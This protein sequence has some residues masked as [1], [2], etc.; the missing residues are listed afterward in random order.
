MKP[1]VSHPQP[2]VPE[3]RS[4]LAAPTGAEVDSAFLARI[5]RILAEQESP[6][7]MKTPPEVQAKVNPE[8]AR[9]AQWMTPE[10]L[11]RMTDD[12]NLQYHYGGNDVLTWQSPQG[13]VVLAVGYDQIGRVLDHLTPEQNLAVCT[14]FAHPW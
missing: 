12:F 14:R 10:A 5:D 2:T 3:P 7:L 9:L 6:P 8:A 13:L 1:D 11:Q 4:S